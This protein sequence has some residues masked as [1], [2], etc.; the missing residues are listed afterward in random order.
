MQPDQVLLLAETFQREPSCGA[1]GPHILETDGTT[2]L[3]MRRTPRLRS[4]FAEAFFLNNVLPG[5]SWTSELV[6]DGYEQAREVEW[7]SGA[8]LCARRTA[9][10]EVGGFDERFFLYSE[11]VDLCTRLRRAGY[12]LRYEPGPIARHAG[13][14]SAPRPG[15]VALKAEARIT[16][17]RLHESTPRY[18]AFRAAYVLNE[19]LAA[20][21]G[22]YPVARPSARPPGGARRDAR[23]PTECGGGLMSERGRITDYV[24][25]RDQ[26]AVKGLP[27]GR[28]AKL[29]RTVTTHDMRAWA[30][31]NGT[32]VLVPLAKR[33]AQSLAEG[34]RI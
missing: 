20:P 27:R 31:L 1:A 5:A 7:L 23:A 6:V 10:E 2:Q 32:T 29:L 12:R 9:F 3:S 22:G 21:A 4:A 30:K 25:S 24:A 19:L 14:G 16:Y 34:R 15:Q 13:G 28:A 8:V 26:H 33:K 11:D 17:S 18:A